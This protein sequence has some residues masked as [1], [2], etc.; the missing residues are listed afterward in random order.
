MQDICL[1]NFFQAEN[2]GKVSNKSLA[3]TQI[4]TVGYMAPELFVSNIICDTQCDIF[5]MGVILFMMA[6]GRTPFDTN[7]QKEVL[8]QSKINLQ[9]AERNEKCI[10]IWEGV[11]KNG[12][13]SESGMNLL[14]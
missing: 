14:Q 12:K 10:I 5:S 11:N 13:L 7:D 1:V 3:R 6:F 2:L 8:L 4:G 9:L